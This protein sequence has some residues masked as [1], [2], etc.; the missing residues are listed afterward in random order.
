MSTLALNIS[1]FRKEAGL[2]QE[3]L[4]KSLDVTQTVIWR[5]ERGRRKPEPERLLEL[6]DALG[7]TTDA[8]LGRN[9]G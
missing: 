4:A 5:Y 7:V 2:T 3:E 9:H 8:L 1:R 6:A